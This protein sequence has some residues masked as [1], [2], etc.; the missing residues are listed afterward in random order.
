MLFF[1]ISV[2]D[3]LSERV[4]NCFSISEAGKMRGLFLLCS[5]SY[6]FSPI[7]SFSWQFEYFVQEMVLNITS[8]QFSV[9]TRYDT[10]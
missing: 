4:M 9:K 2:F 1:I 3:R 7:G 8:G 6:N 10:N 5:A